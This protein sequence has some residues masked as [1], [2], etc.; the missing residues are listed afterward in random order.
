MIEGIAWVFSPKQLSNA[1]FKVADGVKNVFLL[2]YRSDLEE[3]ST[4]CFPDDSK[5]FPSAQDSFSLQIFLD[6]QLIGD[7]A[8]RILNREGAYQRCTETSTL[9]FGSSLNTKGFS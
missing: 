1:R 5:Y 7:A 3:Y 9:L 4:L 6:L 2:R 8:D